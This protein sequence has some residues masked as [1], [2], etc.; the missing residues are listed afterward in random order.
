MKED[1]IHPIRKIPYGCC[2]F[3]LTPL[4]IV[5]SEITELELDVN[6]YPINNDNLYY[7]NYARCS[8]CGT[9]VDMI[10]VGIQFKPYCRIKEFVNESNI[11]RE[12]N[13]FVKG[14]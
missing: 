3:C 8:K 13:P 1:L 14:E 10:K 6:G 7:K 11:V 9:E 5:E 4:T 12:N 2:P